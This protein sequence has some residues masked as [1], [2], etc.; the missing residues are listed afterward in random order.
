VQAR[1]WT[2]EEL[3]SKREI[4]LEL[5][6]YQY[7]RISQREHLALKGTANRF[8][9]LLFPLLFSFSGSVVVEYYPFFSLLM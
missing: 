1:K 4:C 6:G 5:G 7:K 3:L 8:S 9:E 2:N